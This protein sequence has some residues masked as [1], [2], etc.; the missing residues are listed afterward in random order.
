MAAP[1]TTAAPRKER[2]ERGQPPPPPW[3][4]RVL[5]RTVLG[6][7]VLILFTALG[8]AFSGAVLYSY[9]EYRLDKNESLIDDYARS[10]TAARDSIRA[11]RDDAMRQIDEQL[12]PIKQI[13]SEGKT[14]RDLVTKAGEAVWF[15]RTLDEVG[16]PSVG[17]A[18]VVASDGEETF[19]LA[20]YTTVRAATR[21]PAPDVVVS[22]G[23]EEF[24]A[25]VHTWE[26]GRDLALLIIPRGDTPKL[27]WAGGDPVEVGQR[28]FVLSGRGTAGGAAVQGFVADV[29]Q[30]AIQ[31]DAA[32][33]APFQ[34]GPLVNTKGEVLGI[35]SRAYAPFNFDPQA[36]FFAV[37]IRA[38]CD[39]VLSCP[40]GTAAGAGGAGGPPPAAPPGP[41]P[42]QPA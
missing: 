4:G 10:F 25:R 14:L 40:G 6:I 9:Y 28:I 20:S 23:E 30:Q 38:A 27:G 8:A 13:A 11:E 26:P 35:A 33:G 34:G 12:E 16:Q 41:P 21:K 5:P 3:K 15:V 37:P 2:T 42:S 29:S 1:P 24:K 36:V 32:V 19:L 17:S 31:H 39:K 7:S 18:F 22:H